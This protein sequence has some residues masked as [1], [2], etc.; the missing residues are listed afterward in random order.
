MCK[1]KSSRVRFSGSISIGFC[2]IRGPQNDYRVYPGGGVAAHSA[3]L[4][5]NLEP[6]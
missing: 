2:R 4:S 6:S 3:Q 1:L 5:E